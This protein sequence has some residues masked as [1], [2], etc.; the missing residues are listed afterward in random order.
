VGV[1]AEDIADSAKTRV[2]DRAR[3]DF[4]GIAHPKL[5]LSFDIPAHP[6]VSEIDHLNEIIYLDGDQTEECVVNHEIVKL[7]SVD[8]QKF[9]A[10]VPPDINTIHFRT[11]ERGK[12]FREILVV[13]SRD[14][15][16]LPRFGKMRDKRQK[17][18]IVAPKTVE[19]QI[20]KNISK[21]DQFLELEFFQ[22]FSRFPR[23]AHSR[24]QMQIGND[25]RV[26]FVF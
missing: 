1:P 3:G 18:P 15:A 2:E 6:F 19:V 8:G 22:E 13:I 5:A 26:G 14:P 21:Q 24:S 17:F 10:S 9:F 12:N 4:F 25:E 20:F 7:V 23:A 11:G 16:H